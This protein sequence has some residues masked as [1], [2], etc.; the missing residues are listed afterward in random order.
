MYLSLIGVGE[1]LLWAVKIKSEDLSSHK[2]SLL[3]WQAAQ[4]LKLAPGN[5]PPRHW[6]I[7]NLTY[8][9]SSR[10]MGA[11]GGWRRQHLLRLWKQR[12]AELSGEH[13]EILIIGG[14]LTWSLMNS[15]RSANVFLGN[16]ET[17]K[18]PLP[19]TYN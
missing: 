17:N 9:Y 4:D 12:E 6:F 1:A 8:V 13:K 19:S 14:I 16:P 3:S 18:L 2:R 7:I 11:K 15:R 10:R 5:L